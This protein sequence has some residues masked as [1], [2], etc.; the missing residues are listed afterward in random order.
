MTVAFWGFFL[1]VTTFGLIVCVPGLKMV[2]TLHCND[3]CVDCMCHSSLPE[4]LLPQ[5]EFVCLVSHGAAHVAR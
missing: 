2:Q 3:P 1:L 4:H 5:W